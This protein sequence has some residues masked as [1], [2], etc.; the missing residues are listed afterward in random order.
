VTGSAE[1]RRNSIAGGLAVLFIRGVLLWV[2]V[3]FATCGWLIVWVGRRGRLVRL[4]QFLGWIDLNLIACIQ[5]TVIRP[6]VRWPVDWVPASAMRQ[7]TH[8]LRVIDF[9]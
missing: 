8:R 1:P 6:L 9:D 3:P 4:G 5:R 2:I 7:I